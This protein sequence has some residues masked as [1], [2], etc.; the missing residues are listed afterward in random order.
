MDMKR[1]KKSASATKTRSHSTTINLTKDQIDGIV[2][3]FK[4]IKFEY[5]RQNFV[6][7]LSGYLFHNR[8][9]LDSTANVVWNF[10]RVT[11]DERDYH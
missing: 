11:R 6:L 8:I 5:S 7:G 9:S 1:M 3:L 10:C 4:D 2:N